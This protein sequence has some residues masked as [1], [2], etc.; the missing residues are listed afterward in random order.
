MALEAAIEHKCKSIAFPAIST[1][2]YRFPIADAAAIA[3]DVACNFL[4]TT[5]GIS[6]V[7]FVLYKQGQY[8]VFAETLDDWEPHK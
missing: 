7:R 6:L 1:G 2:A 3:I 4:S 5:S 8:D